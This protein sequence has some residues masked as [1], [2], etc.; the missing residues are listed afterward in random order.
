MNKYKLLGAALMFS[1]IGMI[2]AMFHFGMT[3][4]Q[5]A[6]QSSWNFLALLSL[7]CVTLFGS[8]AALT[9]DATK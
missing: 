1:I 2:V 3:G 5:W 6:S 7:L 9:L 4:V 8:F